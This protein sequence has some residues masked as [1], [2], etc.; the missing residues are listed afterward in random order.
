[1]PNVLKL[2]VCRLQPAVRLSAVTHVL[3][4]QE[5]DEPPRVNTAARQASLKQASG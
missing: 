3:K 4:E 2:A 1:M 5:V